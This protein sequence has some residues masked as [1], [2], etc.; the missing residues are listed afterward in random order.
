MENEICVYIYIYN[1]GSNNMIEYTIIYPYI[2]TN[3]MELIRSHLGSIPPPFSFVPTE[4]ATS[5][6]TSRADITE[7]RWDHSHDIHLLLQKK[8][9]PL[10][11]IGFT[12]QNDLQYWLMFQKSIH[13]YPVYPNKLCNYVSSEARGWKL[14][15]IISV[16][17]VMLDPLK[18]GNMFP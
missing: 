3:L 1:I 10:R 17:K 14:F 7:Q 2:M 9:Q 8:P 4:V 15:S 6:P 12:Q 5:Q 11:F 18:F 16:Q 13:I